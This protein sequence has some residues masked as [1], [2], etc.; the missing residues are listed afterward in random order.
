MS[1]YV[2]PSG[3][4][5]IAMNKQT[6]Y[7]LLFNQ[8]VANN[9]TNKQA[10][11][12]CHRIINEQSPEDIQAIIDGQKVI[13][14]A[15]EPKHRAGAGPLIPSLSEIVAELNQDLSKKR[16]PLRT[17]EAESFLQA[18]RVLNSKG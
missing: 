11:L 16:E 4:L 13:D 2:M 10:I 15:P 12:N 7:Q 5:K 14:I 17:I 1:D 3:Q 6:A 18:P 9:Y 8:H